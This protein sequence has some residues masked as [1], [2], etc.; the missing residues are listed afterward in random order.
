ML[1]TLS[2]YSD[3]CQLISIKL[4]KNIADTTPLDPWQMLGDK[5]SMSLFVSWY[6]NLLIC[7]QWTRP[8]N[9]IAT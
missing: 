2:L 1:Y 4:E 5:A 6:N 9:C 3:V 8:E 7:K